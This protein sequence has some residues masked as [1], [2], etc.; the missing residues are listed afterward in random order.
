MHSC[1]TAISIS[2]DMM[3][4]SNID[5]PAYNRKVTSES[6]TRTIR[7]IK[8]AECCTKMSRISTTLASCRKYLKKRQTVDPHTFYIS[9][10]DGI[11]VFLHL[12]I[13]I[14]R[15]VIAYLLPNKSIFP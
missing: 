7:L 3:R 11:S 5:N 9:T 4:T 10:L 12:Y 15:K 14:W 1:L 2:F 13:K 8:K 6:H